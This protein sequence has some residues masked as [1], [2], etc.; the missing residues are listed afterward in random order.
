MK[1]HNSTNLILFTFYEYLS[2]THWFSCCD[3]YHAATPGNG[4]TLQVF[5]I[6][7]VLKLIEKV[8]MSDNILED[9]IAWLLVNTMRGD[10]MQQLQLWHQVRP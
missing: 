6:P 4:Q 8:S 5:V 3:F 2:I 7:E 10:E 9:I 1:K